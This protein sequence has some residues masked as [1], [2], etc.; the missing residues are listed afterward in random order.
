ME[1]SEL[2]LLINYRCRHVSNNTL[3]WKRSVE[4]NGVCESHTNKNIASIEQMTHIAIS[5]IK[6]IIDNYGNCVSNKQKSIVIQKFFD[7]STDYFWLSLDSQIFQSMLLNKLDEF[8]RFKNVINEENLIKYRKLIC[9]N[10]YDSSYDATSTIFE[11]YKSILNDEYKAKS[12]KLTVDL[13]DYSDSEL[14]ANIV[15]VL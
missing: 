13:I 12:D 7:K 8:N 1:D 6:Q 11:H 10:V 15:V 4:K 9:P 14:D 3:C 2:E 5:E